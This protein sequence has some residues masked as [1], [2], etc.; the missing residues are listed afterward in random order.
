M[1]RNNADKA[2]GIVIN[3]WVLE[4]YRLDKI[5]DRK[6]KYLVVDVGGIDS[7]GRLETPDEEID[8]FLNFIR[9]Y[10]K[11]NNYDFVL[12][13]YTEVNTY[14]YDIESMNFK[15]NL[16]GM[17]KDLNTKGFDGHFVDIEPVQFNQRD[18][19]I[20]FLKELKNKN[21][22]IMV[23]YSG[24]I[25][26]D[27]ENE[28]EWEWDVE[29]FRKAANIADIITIPGYDTDLNDKID[30]KNKLKE[31]VRLL[32]KENFNTNILLG[33]PTHKNEPETI[34]NALNFYNEAIEEHGPDNIIGYSIFS[35]WTM[36]DDEWGIFDRFI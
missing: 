8:E 24:D 15:E 12:L 36:E 13:P 3:I 9:D 35:E 26:D 31:Q 10:E 4:D 14:D 29:F 32:N 30:Y 11:E 5:R 2:N 23:V 17:Y 7:A 28:N 21:L 16:I 1:T 20:E 33:I 34:D 6:I 18:F 27:S 25:T 22:G 19:Y